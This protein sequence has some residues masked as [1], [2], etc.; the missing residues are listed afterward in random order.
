[1]ARAELLAAATNRTAPAIA[2]TCLLPD[3]CF[4]YVSLLTCKIQLTLIKS[5]G[6]PKSNGENDQTKVGRS[7]ESCIN[8]PTN[9]QQAAGGY[10]ATA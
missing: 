4:M 7:I 2:N 9:Y 1:M 8:S 3:K 5:R 6:L 10:G